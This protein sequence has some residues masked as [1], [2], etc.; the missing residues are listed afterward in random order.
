MVRGAHVNRR[1][2]AAD[3][4]RSAFLEKD[5]LRSREDAEASSETESHVKKTWIGAERPD[6]VRAPRRRTIRTLH[7]Q[8]MRRP[9]LAYPCTSAFPVCIR[10]HTKQGLHHNRDKV[11]AGPPTMLDLPARPLAQ[12]ADRRPGRVRPGST[13]RSRW[14]S[15][16][17]FLNVKAGSGVMRRIFRLAAGKSAGP[18]RRVATAKSHGAAQQVRRAGQRL[19]WLV[20]IGWRQA[21]MLVLL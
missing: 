10:P 14:Y 8:N 21:F 18:S 3:T 9:E 11:A 4:E 20:P 7:R 5:L 12:S 1:T 16:F 17:P 6:H 15:Y 2:A 13:P 19:L